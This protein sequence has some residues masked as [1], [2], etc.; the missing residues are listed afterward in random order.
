[1]NCPESF[2]NAQYWL[3]CLRENTEWCRIVLLGNK[4]DLENRR[5]T[6]SEAQRY[7]RDNGICYAEVS[8]KS[9]YQVE[10]VL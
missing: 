3:R 5:I 9:G 10:A 7:A 8:A 2:Q 1:M 4:G 6:K